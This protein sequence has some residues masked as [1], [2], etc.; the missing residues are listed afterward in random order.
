MSRLAPGGQPGSLRARVYDVIFGNETRL[1]KIFDVGLIIA[2]IASVAVVMLDSVPGLRA[3]WGPWLR[4]LEWMF[5]LGFTAEYVLRLWCVKRADSYAFSFFGAIDLLAVIPTYVSLVLPGGQ[6]LAVVRILRVVRVFRVLKL[7]QYMG[8][9][10]ALAE[11]LRASRYKISV[12]LLTVVSIVVVVG[13]LMYLIEGPESG[14]TSIPKGV[15]WAVVTLTTVGYGDVAPQTS[16]GQG[17]ASIVMILGYGI[18][19]VPTG[20]VSAEL[21]MVAT[22][23]PG[24]I[25]EACAYVET[26]PEARFCKRCGEAL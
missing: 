21:A 7:V 22:R 15:Y 3:A 13:S 12:F 14:F 5:T 2:I 10:S 26:D 1:G 8:E 19:A 6:F 24:S 18:I 25:C 9:A 4:A 17:V 11:A 23:R 20:I 16:L